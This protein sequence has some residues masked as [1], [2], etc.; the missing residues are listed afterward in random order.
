MKAAVL[1]GP[2]DLRI[3]ECE[4]PKVGCK[5]VLVRIA[6]CGICTLEQRLFLGDQKIFYPLVAGHEASGIVEE[7][8]EQVLADLKPGDRVALDLLNR[9]GECY[10]C[11]IGSD[12]LCENRFKK[13]L[14]LMGGF[15]EY[16]SVPAA[17][18][19]KIS[20]GLT[21][22]EAALTEPVSTCVHSLNSLKLS[23]QETIVISGVGIMGM[24]HVLLAKLRGI[25]V[26]AS[27]IDDSR[28]KQA[29]ALGA[30]IVV[31]PEESPLRDVVKQATSGRGADA[32]VL[33]TPA[34]S[35][36]TDA[37]SSVRLGGRIALFAKSSKGFEIPVSPDHLHAKEITLIGVQGRTSRD[38]QEAVA[39]LNRGRLDLRPLVSNTVPLEQIEE[40]MK[41]A[42]DRSTYRVVVR[43][44][45]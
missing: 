24:L 18:L 11:R 3:T 41:L 17:Q 30:D 39:L 42:L 21:F 19:F 12:H 37:L 31:N 14:N 2:E 6:A 36:F 29:E 10:F 26:I 5:E 15:G 35:A 20:H 22:E 44:N 38:F 32:I 28:L 9:C 8:D 16:V 23:A 4:K 34:Q 45:T 40:G 25:Q 1:Y 33:A 43:M 7:V 27:D 13:G